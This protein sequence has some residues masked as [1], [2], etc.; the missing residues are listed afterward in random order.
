MSKAQHTQGPWKYEARC[1]SS[2]HSSIESCVSLKD[3]PFSIWIPSPPF[4]LGAIGALVAVTPDN[5]TQAEANARL[6]AA[7]PDLLKAC[8]ATLPFIEWFREMQM[9]DEIRCSPEALQ[10]ASDILNL[11]DYDIRVGL[12]AAIALATKPKETK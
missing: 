4:A 10:Q 1:G 3:Y 2:I 5:P 8:K 9:K 6:I 11:H 12:E 7:S